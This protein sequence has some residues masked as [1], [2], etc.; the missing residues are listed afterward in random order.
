MKNTMKRPERQV[1]HKLVKLIYVSE[2]TL[3]FNYGQESVDP[4]DGIMLFGPYSQDKIGGQI[5]VGIIGPER[6]RSYLKEYLQRIHK[7]IYG[8]AEAARPFFPGLEAA[9]GVF[10][11][12]HGLKEIEVPASEISEYLRYA[13]PHQRVYNLASLY[14]SRLEQYCAQEEMPVNVWFVIIPDEIFQLGRPRSRLTDSKDRVSVGLSKADRRSKDLFLFDELTELKA[15]YEFEVDF[16]NQVKA[17]LLGHRIVTQIVR[18]STIAYETIWNNDDRIE[19]EKKFDT[20]KAWNIAT[21][22]YYK[23]GG[24]PWRLGNVRDGVCYVGL[25]YKKLFTDETDRSACCA[26]QLFLDSGDGLVFR[27]NIGPWFNPDTKEFHLARNDAA[28]LI[29]QSLKAFKEN[30]PEKKFP[31]EV[32]IHAKTYF[33]DEEWAGFC[34]A[35]AGRTKLVG[36]RIREDKAFKLYR[37]FAYSVPRGTALLIGTRKAFLWTK[38]F[39]PRIQTQLGLET[40]NPLEIKITRGD[41]DLVTV[42]ADV[43]ALTKLNYNSCLYGDGIPVTLRFAERIGEVLTAGTEVVTGV[44]PFKHYV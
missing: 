22:L 8:T 1:A 44:L 24:L 5:N 33:D 2:P 34:D 31:S 28:D 14:T 12:F 40:P 11:N 13:D 30:A 36:V 37:E 10:I 27:G 18:E 41:P 38:G 23:V 42:C 3:R 6:Q 29:H 9:F 20:A 39:I 35:A 17:R 25:V 21:T 26:A 15:A 7:P 4:R 19:Y 16:H 32:F 43:L